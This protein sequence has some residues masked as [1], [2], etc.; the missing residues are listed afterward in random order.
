MLN[1]V[2]LSKEQ[3]CNSYIENYNRII[4]E[5]LS[6]FLYGKNKCRISWPLLLYFIINEENEYK[7]NIIKNENEV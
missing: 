4:K 3:R 6:N 2:Y 5:K 7:N 1:Y